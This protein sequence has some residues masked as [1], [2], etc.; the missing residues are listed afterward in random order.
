MKDMLGVA[1]RCVRRTTGVL[2]LIVACILVALWTRSH[3]F[4]DRL[5][6]RIQG[7]SDFIVASKQGRVT[8]FCFKPHGHPN[9]WKWE[10]LSYPVDDELSFPGWSP[11]P[12]NFFYGFRLIGNQI[13]PVMRST[14]QTPDGGTVMLMGAA[15]ATLRGSGLVLPYWFL[16]ATVTAVGFLLARR[17]LLR[18]GV[19]TMLVMLTLAAV[20]M[21]AIRTIDH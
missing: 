17:N 12:S 20:M 7:H 6:G 2:L 21:G 18:F 15:T 14:W 10:T 4:A 16:V 8:I 19:R 1:L 9:W 5:H 3:S 13:Y 11:Q